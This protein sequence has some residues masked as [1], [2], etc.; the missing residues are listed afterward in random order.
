M[1]KTGVSLVWDDS[2]RWRD[3]SWSQFKERLEAT[4]GGV[5]VAADDLI[6]LLEYKP[7]PLRDKTWLQREAYTKMTAA[8]Q[9]PEDVRLLA[10]IC[11]L[12]VAQNRQLEAAWAL[13]RLRDEQDILD[14]PRVAQVLN[15]LFRHNETHGRHVS[16][17][18][19]SFAEQLQ[20]PL[21]VLDIVRERGR[22]DPQVLKAIDSPFVFLA[23]ARDDRDKVS[24]IRDLLQEAGCVAWLDCR[25]LVPGD[26]W[27]V[28]LREAI[29]RADF[30]VPCVSR[31]TQE[32]KR[33]FHQE[34]DLALAHRTGTTGLPFLVPVRLDD[35]PLDEDIQN[36]QSVDAFPDIDE[37][38]RA[39][40]R[41]VWQQ[42]R[43]SGSA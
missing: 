30:F 33:Y 35:V 8:A 10:I 2:G 4:H 7:A 6:E 39:L 23:Y 9:T 40:C 21:M 3:Q 32:R 12:M 24:G 37:G 34:V 26:E 15:A 1:S 16:R 11:D 29:E 38:T 18:L 13:V 14:A 36:F 20:P 17:V 28:K 43:K 22:L 25:D 41:A 27:Q 31:R 5:G 42:F 19:K